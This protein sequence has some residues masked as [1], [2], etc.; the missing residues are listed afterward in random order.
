MG[1]HLYL[2][3]HRS[4]VT[5]IQR[6]IKKPVIWWDHP[7]S[8]KNPNKA[9]YRTSFHTRKPN[10]HYFLLSLSIMLC[11]SGCLPQ[12]FYVGSWFPVLF[13]PVRAKKINAHDYITCIFIILPLSRLRRETAMQNWHIITMVKHM[14]TCRKHLG[15]TA[16][17]REA[18][19]LVILLFGDFYKLWSTCVFFQCF[20]PPPKQLCYQKN[21][22]ICLTYVTINPPCQIQ[23]SSTLSYAI[24]FFCF[25]F[26]KIIIA[27]SNHRKK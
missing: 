20:S 6:A 24:W 10:Q 27:L 8:S 26:S 7:S 17:V 22:N 14:R 16:N 15:R 21:S 12:T 4:F 25:P 2:S 1:I 3:I 9:K 18:L 5:V 13:L 23:L 11:I 19:I